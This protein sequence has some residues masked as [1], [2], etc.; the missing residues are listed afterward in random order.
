MKCYLF[1]LLLLLGC[2]F[3][4]A[5]LPLNH[6][7]EVQEYVHLDPEFSGFEQRMIKNSVTEWSTTTHGFIIWGFQDWP[8]YDPSSPLFPFIN[9][10]NCTKHLLIMRMISSDKS[11]VDID[12]SLNSITLGYAKKTHDLC[13]GIDTIFLV[14]DR[15]RTIDELR[16]I[17]LHEIGH[18]LGLKHDVTNSIMEPKGF[19]AKCI[20]HRDFVNFCK[21]WKCDPDDFEICH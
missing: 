9:E 13:R 21:L 1:C 8:L 19:H 7:A 12:T 11:I 17:T 18:I 3:T 5:H 15:I 6:S 10:P 20:T 2:G 14:M 4:P 16:L